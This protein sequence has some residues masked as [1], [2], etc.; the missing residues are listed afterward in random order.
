MPLRK[1]RSTKYRIRTRKTTKKT[2]RVF[3]RRKTSKRKC[4]ICKK[5]L[6]PTA[7]DSKPK[8]SRKFGNYLCHYC[9]QM[10]I[11]AAVRVE[12]KIIGI[13]SVDL[14]YKKYVEQMIKK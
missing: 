9:T 1:N 2:K 11:K 12:N 8:A 5:N 10:V 4:A 7:L 6:A 14:I 13:E 3:L